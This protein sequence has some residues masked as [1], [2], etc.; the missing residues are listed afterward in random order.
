M[1]IYKL[2]K[3]DREDFDEEYWELTDIE[4]DE[5]VKSELE[6]DR[7]L[8]ARFGRS[9]DLNVLVNDP[10]AIVRFAVA[11]EG[12]GQDLDKLVEDKDADVRFAVAK[13]GR[14]QD[15][16]RLIKDESWE[17]RAGVAEQDRDQDLDILVHDSAVMVRYTIAERS[18]K[19]HYLG[20][21]S[22]DK[23]KGVRDM[24]IMRL[25]TF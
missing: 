8:A 2:P 25:F 19:K 9:K 14:P 24:A 16:D 18:K 3:A 15:L 6:E 13:Q 10:S 21:L 20:I 4:L 11:C 7:E 5:L 23:D 1:T 12:R 22:Q 17:V